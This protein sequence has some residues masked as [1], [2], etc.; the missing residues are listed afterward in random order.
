MNPT[1]LKERAESQNR[2]G[3]KGNF[4]FSAIL[5][6]CGSVFSAAHAQSAADVVR[7]VNGAEARIAYSATQIVQRGGARE[8]ARIYRSGVKR[9]LEWVEPSIK[10]GDFLLDDGQNVWLYHRADNSAIQ[11]KSAGRA[12]NLVPQGWKLGVPI[13]QNGRLVRVLTRGTGRKILV[14]ARTSVIIGTRS[15]ANATTLQNIR[16][17]NIPDSK[18]QFVKPPSATVTRLDGTLFGNLNLARR[19]APW[20]KV[21]AQMPANFRL[22]SAVVGQREAWLRYTNGQKRFSIFEQ[23][24]DAGEIGPRAVDGGWFWKRDNLR[25][26]VTGAPASAIA[27]MASSLK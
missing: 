9:R 20:L 17:G 27:S 15:G 2:R 25:F 4:L 19:R 18:W 3:R 24:A 10:R 7:E 6:L 26:L 16:F 5:C 11:T 22:E 8:V 21:P 13:Q 12:R 23:K 14:D 1:F